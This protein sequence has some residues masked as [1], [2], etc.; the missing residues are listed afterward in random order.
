[1]RRIVAIGT[2]EKSWGLRDNLSAYLAGFAYPWLTGFS[3]QRGEK[4]R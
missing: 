2:E 1:M 4:L 3:L